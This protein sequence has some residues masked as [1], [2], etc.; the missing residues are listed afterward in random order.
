ME[1]LQLVVKA[2]CVAQIQS[3]AGGYL[4]ACN[5]PSAKFEDVSELEYSSVRYTDV[6][7]GKHVR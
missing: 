3:G 2:E 4:G 5:L 1:I 6:G 7:R